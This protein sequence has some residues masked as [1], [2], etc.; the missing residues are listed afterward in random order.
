MSDKISEKI[1]DK[2]SQDV[3]NGSSNS[4]AGKNGEEV[5]EKQ[6]LT[7]IVLLTTTSLM[8]MFLIAL[9]RTIITTVTNC[10]SSLYLLLN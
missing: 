6:T 4:D 3:E 9:D 10:Y 1:P 8:A 5:F 2:Q 7:T